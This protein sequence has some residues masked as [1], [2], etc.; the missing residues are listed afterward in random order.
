MAVEKFK[1]A[2][3][4]SYSPRKIHNVPP[5]LNEL[6]S[7]NALWSVGFF[8]TGVDEDRV[9]KDYARELQGRIHVVNHYL[10]KT[11]PRAYPRL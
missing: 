11:L 8:G 4:G 10:N 5:V 9:R 3:I 6:L 7:K 2:L 1:V